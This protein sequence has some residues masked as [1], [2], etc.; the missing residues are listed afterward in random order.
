[1]RCTKCGTEL[2]DGAN[3]CLDCGTNLQVVN[4]TSQFLPEP[5]RRHLF[6]PPERRR[7][8]AL[9]SDL[10]GYTTMSEKLDPEQ[11]REITGQVFSRVK[12]IIVKHEG[13][14]ERVMGDGVL[15]FFGIP[16]G[17]EDDSIRAIQAATEIHDHVSSMS[18]HYEQTFGVPLAMHSGIDTGLVVTADEDP[19]KGIYGISGDTVNV[20]A[21]VERPRRTGGDYSGRRHPSPGRRILRV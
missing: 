17:H 12:R 6:P 4:V 21:E 2:P 19:Q 20:A 1:M 13:F 15:A 8:T 11:V 7:V 5:T 16:S 3:F 18:P 14:I 10:A 9:F